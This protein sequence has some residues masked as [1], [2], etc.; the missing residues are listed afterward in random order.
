MSTTSD[1]ARQQYEEEGYVI[2]RE[3]LDEELIGEVD[4][5]VAWLQRRHPELRSEALGTRLVNGDPFWI[6][7]VS[8]DRLLDIAEQF[9]GPN[10]ALFASHY[11]S[12]PPYDGLPVTWHQ[13]G[14]YWPLEPMQVVTLWLAV[15]DATAENGCMQVI[16]RTHATEL[17]DVHQ[18][19]DVES[20][21]G[22]GMDPDQVDDEDAVDVILAAGDVSIH[23]PNV[24]HGSRANTSPK[25]RCGLTIRYIPTTTRITSDEP[26]PSAYLLRGEAG[27]ANV[28]QPKPTY[29]DGQHMPF[30]GS[31]TW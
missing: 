17:Q 1:T 4:Q 6:R 9:I 2:V 30:R 23:H 14:S 3:V 5:H 12:K 25:R 13:D 26:W 28:Y 15:D 29:V 22:S 8:D 27:D 31:E 19:D 24:I 20:V 11:I 21:L 7:L 18:R 10:I 16:P